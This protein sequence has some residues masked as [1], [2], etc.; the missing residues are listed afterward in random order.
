MNTIEQLI[1]TARNQ[2]DCHQMQVSG[3]W[4]INAKDFCKEAGVDYDT[5]VDYQIIRETEDN[6]EYEAELINR[7]TRELGY[8][9]DKQLENIRDETSLFVENDEGYSAYFWQNVVKQLEDKLTNKQNDGSI[10]L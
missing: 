6:E 3:V 8:L 4:S 1:Q 5:A 2:M 7:Y 10:E 9:T